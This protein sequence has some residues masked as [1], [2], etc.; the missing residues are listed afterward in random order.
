VR[1]VQAAIKLK[2]RLSALAWPSAPARTC[3]RTRWLSWNLHFVHLTGCGGGLSLQY[4]R[5][6][7]PHHSTPLIVPT[8]GDDTSSEQYAAL[9]SARLMIDVLPEPGEHDDLHLSSCTNCDSGNCSGGLDGSV[10]SWYSTGCT[11]CTGCSGCSSCSNC[12]S[13]CSCSSWSCSSCSSCFCS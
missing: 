13:C 4:M 1:L 6:P 3:H 8:P 12:Y 10:G 11:S 7:A 5:Q 2:P 9:L